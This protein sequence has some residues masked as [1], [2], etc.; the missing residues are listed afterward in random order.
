MCPRTVENISLNKKDTQ[1]G[2]NE[3]VGLIEQA[4]RVNKTP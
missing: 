2:L 3:L 4:L 1:A